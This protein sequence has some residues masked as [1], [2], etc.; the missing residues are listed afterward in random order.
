MPGP[1]PSDPL[2]PTEEDYLISVGKSVA[3]LWRY[4]PA[5]MQEAILNQAETLSYRPSASA[6][7][8]QLRSFL[9]TYGTG[10]GERKQD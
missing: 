9:E 5:A 1:R 6:A 4:M 7:R 8:E 2:E 10:E 3:L